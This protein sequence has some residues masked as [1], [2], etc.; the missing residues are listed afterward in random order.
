VDTAPGGPVVADDVASVG[1]RGAVSRAG[2]GRPAAAVST[3]AAGLAPAGVGAVLR[4]EQF[5]S[6][7]VS[8]RLSHRDVPD[9]VER[10]KDGT[11]L[12]VDQQTSPARPRRTRRSNSRPTR[13]AGCRLRRVL[14]AMRCSAMAIYYIDVDD[15]ITSRLRGSVTRATRASPWSSR[16]LAPGDVADQLQAAAR[17]H[18]IA[19]APG[20]I[21]GTL[22]PIAGADCGPAVLPVLRLPASG[23]GPTR[24]ISRVGRRGR[25]A[26]EELAATVGGADAG[27]KA[28]LRVRRSSGRVPWCNRRRA[29]APVRSRRLALGRPGARGGLVWAAGAFLLLPSATIVLT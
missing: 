26:L 4:S 1:R 9:Q 27:R 7:S 22:G 17:E 13:S 29:R 10:I 5:W 11:N 3:C 16:R 24:A 12:L 20:V 23:V 6:D 14:R 25:D 8:R 2:G 15:E 19:T 21:A 18:A 28:R